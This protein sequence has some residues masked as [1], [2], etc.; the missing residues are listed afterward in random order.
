MRFCR[1]SMIAADARQ[2]DLRHE[3][4]EHDEGDRQPDQLRSK[5]LRLERRKSA[6]PACAG[7]SVLAVWVGSAIVSPVQD[8]S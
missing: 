2:R 1:L 5:C 3:H 6:V 4:V 7:C 8:V